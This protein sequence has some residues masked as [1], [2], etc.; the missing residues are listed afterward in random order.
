MVMCWLIG[1]DVSGV[2]VNHRRYYVRAP[3]NENKQTIYHNK[4]SSSS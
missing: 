3:L 2:I 1:S 4:S